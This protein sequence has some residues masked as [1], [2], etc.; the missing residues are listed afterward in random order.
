MPEEFLGVELT[1]A[2]E[3]LFVLSGKALT[4]ADLETKRVETK[5]LNQAVARFGPIDRIAAIDDDALLVSATKTVGK[6]R[7]TTVYALR[8][9]DLR[10]RKVASVSP[11]RFPGLVQFAWDGRRVWIAWPDVHRGVDRGVTMLTSVVLPPTW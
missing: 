3:T 11:V 5:S 9:R 6:A 4:H 2:G 7:T 8:Y 10:Y 1:A